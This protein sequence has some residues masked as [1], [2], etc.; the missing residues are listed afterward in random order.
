M[1]NDDNRQDALQLEALLFSREY[2]YM[3]A[4]KLFGGA[5]DADLIET[6]LSDATADVVDEIAGDDATLAG[7]LG[8]LGEL[9]ARDA[10]GLLE[11]AR[12]EYARIFVGPQALPAS[13]YESPYTGA[14]DMGLF[15]ENTLA[16]RAWYRERGLRAKRL[17]AVPDDHVSMM[18][19]F[20]AAQAARAL[21]L[22]RAGC[23]AEL[24]ASL[25]DQGAFVGAH[26]ANW[27]GTFATS[28]RNSRAGARAVLYP[29]ML[30]AFAALVRVDMAL[31]A[32]ASYWAESQ[33]DAEPAAPAPELAEAARA[34]D[35]LASIRPFGIQD[36]ELVPVD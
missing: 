5:P 19:A 15:Q 25:R 27:V 23:F 12:D 35:A 30:E 32:E 29:Q 11:D 18:C 7:L 17:Q 3:L 1:E 33:P 28:V 21:S 4:H 34:L 9:R 6:L 14:H 22:L 20:M 16:V 31:L 24:A 10:A 13:P 26:L 36:N 8:F 2:L